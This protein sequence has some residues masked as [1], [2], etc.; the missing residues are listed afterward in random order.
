MLRAVPIRHNDSQAWQGDRHCGPSTRFLSLLVWFGEIDNTR[1][2]SLLAHHHS[3]RLR[4]AALAAFASLTT[5]ETLSAVSLPPRLRMRPST[6]TVSTFE[7]CAAVT[8]IC[9]GSVKTPRL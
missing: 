9:A 4:S 6:T 1:R 8:I 5:C 2:R 7:G 3:A